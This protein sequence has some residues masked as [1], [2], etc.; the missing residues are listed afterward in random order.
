MS[1]LD[2][3]IA[4]LLEEQRVVHLQP[5]RPRRLRTLATLWAW[6]ALGLPCREPGRRCGTCGPCSARA[7]ALR[8][9]CP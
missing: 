9:W 7:E 5:A 3:L 4:A 6:G 1:A 8:T 2:V